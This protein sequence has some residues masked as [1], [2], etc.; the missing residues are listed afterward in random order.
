MSLFDAPNTSLGKKSG[1][2]FILARVK[3][4]VL[5]QYQTDRQADQDYTCDK[6]IGKI[7][8]EP[9]YDGKSNINTGKASSKPAYPIF[10]FIRQYPN[11]N[12]IVLILSGPSSKMNDGIDRQD[13]WYFPP[14]GVWNSVHTN[15]F[16][17]MEEWRN[18]CVSKISQPGYDAK[19]LEY[20]SLPQGNTFIEKNNIKMLR[21]FEG[22]T[23]FQGRWGQS[24]R[25]GSTVSELKT[26]NP[27][28]NYGPDGD[29]I[30]M[31]VNS[32]K[33]Y[34]PTEKDSP[35]TIEDIN[36]DGSAIYLTSTQAVDIDD[37]KLYRVRSYSLNASS[38]PVTS[39]VIL[40]ERPPIS[41]EFI[42][43]DDQD[44]QSI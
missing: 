10:P 6:D 32:Q 2:H 23:I 36:R 8:Y 27:W 5:G 39:T 21:P 43:P 19:S 14:F 37:I 15:P 20:L 29:P 28:S 22:D 3:K 1:L 12:E 34:F 35:T 31:I 40:P 17:N 18:Y 16:P 38:N 33:R 26:I 13:S 4:I 24:I 11:L 7:F 41:N 42:S 9:L 44:R 25:M 30:L